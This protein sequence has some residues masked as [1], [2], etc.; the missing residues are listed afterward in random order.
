MGLKP[1]WTRLKKP[2]KKKGEKRGEVPTQLDQR[3]TFSI[4][5]LTRK[6]VSNGLKQIRVSS[7]EKVAG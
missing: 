5:T 4:T 7:S 6:C 2:E 3:R 1:G